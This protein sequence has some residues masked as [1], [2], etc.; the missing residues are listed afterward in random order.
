MKK[1]AVEEGLGFQLIL[2]PHTRRAQ[3]PR[4]SLV[5]PLISFLDGSIS[6]CET[7]STPSVSISVDEHPQVNAGSRAT[8]QLLPVRLDSRRTETRHVASS[9]T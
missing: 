8:P 7:L 1:Q 2:K 3:T 4:N 5:N 9:C 6:E